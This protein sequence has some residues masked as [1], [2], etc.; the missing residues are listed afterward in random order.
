M[1]HASEYEISIHKH[2]VCR[3]GLKFYS[4]WNFYCLNGIL[5]VTNDS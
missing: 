1:P 3:N 2:S 4:V 5:E